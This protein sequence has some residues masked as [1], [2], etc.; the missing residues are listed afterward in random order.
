MDTEN[1]QQSRHHIT[2]STAWLLLRLVAGI[3][4]LETA[5]VAFIALSLV[6]VF[7]SL[8][9]EVTIGLWVLQTIKFLLL[10]AFVVAIVTPWASTQYYLTEHQLIKYVG[11]SRRDEEAYDLD[12][13]KAVSLHQGWFGRIF[14]YGDIHLTFSSGN[15][16]EPKLRGVYNPKKYGRV[17]REYLDATG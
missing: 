13:L 16:T 10:T 5:Y 8:H 1:L 4:L 12:I 14:N 15:L 11:L 17:L 3:F 2:N 9:V 6:P 7:T